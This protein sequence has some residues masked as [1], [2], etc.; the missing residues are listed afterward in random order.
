M[1]C[2]WA[3]KPSLIAF[4]VPQTAKSHRLNSY[5][6]TVDEIEAK[7]GLDF[8]TLLEDK[9]EE[10]LESQR[11]EAEWNVERFNPD[12]PPATNSK[13][14]IRVI[15]VGIRIPKCPQSVSRKANLVTKS[16]K[17]FGECRLSGLSWGNSL[18]HGPSHSRFCASE[19]FGS[20]M[21]TF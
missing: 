13:S 11:P 15:P 18:D 19:G 8:F 10:S 21:L 16:G 2:V 6:A 4:Q 14:M 9:L 20:N 3:R 1:L 5:L 7:T 17:T 12:W